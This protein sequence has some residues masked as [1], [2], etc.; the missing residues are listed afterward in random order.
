[1]WWRCNGGWWF[2]RAGWLCQCDIHLN[3]S[4]WRIQHTSWSWHDLRCNVYCSLPTYVVSSSVLVVLFS[5]F[6][7]QKPTDPTNRRLTLLRGW[8]SINNRDYSSRELER[9]YNG[10]DL[11]FFI[12]R[13]PRLAFCQCGALAYLTSPAATTIVIAIVFEQMSLR[14]ALV[15]N[16]SRWLDWRTVL[17]LS[18]SY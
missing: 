17:L 15:P 13:V 6:S 16:G 2:I 18:I 5:S 9:G 14:L 1:M 10:I 4:T 3:Q 11:P 7:Q 8:S 12:P